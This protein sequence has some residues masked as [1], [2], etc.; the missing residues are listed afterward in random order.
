MFDG[1]HYPIE[2]NIAKTKELVN[3]RSRTRICHLKQK[4]VQS[5]VKKTEL[6][7]GANVQTLMNVRLVA[8]LR[9]RL[10]LAAGIGNIHGKYPAQ[11]GRT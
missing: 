7:V 8:D 10:C 1:S 9:S 11:L 2:E 6:S 4:L 5:V 3:S